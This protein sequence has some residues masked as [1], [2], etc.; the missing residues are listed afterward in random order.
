RFEWSYN[1]S[2]I[3][4]N[5]ASLSVGGGSGNPL[6]AGDYSVQVF[7]IN[8][9]DENNNNCGSDID[10]ITILES[11]P[12]EFEVAPTSIG[13]EGQHSLIITN[14]TGEGVYEFSVDNGPWMDLPA[15]GQLAVDGL[16][17]GAHIVY[18]RDKNGCGTTESQV[19]SF[20]DFPP[21]F[22]PN[23]DGYNDTWNI[24]GLDT[25][26]NRAAQI[27]IFDRYGKLLKQI[28]PSSPG[29]DGTFNGNPVPSGDYWFRVEYM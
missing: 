2:L 27:F 15:T 20:I 22:T 10:S 18:G 9:L 17:A 29:W 8:S 4:E 24:I 7:D 14:V 6:Q 13:F 12:P 16:S 28:S 23:D 5:G 26:L 19:I 25:P 11:N 1:G 21:F 3:S